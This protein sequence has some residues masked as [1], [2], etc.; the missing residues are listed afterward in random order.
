MFRISRH[1]R[2]ATVGLILA[3]S[4]LL[5][6]IVAVH[7]FSFQD[8]PSYLLLPPIPND[9]RMPL[10]ISS[11]LYA[12]KTSQHQTEIEPDTLS[13]G[14]TIVTAFQ[15]GRFGDGGSSNIGWATSTDGGNTWKSGFLP[16]TAICRR[17]L[18]ASQRSL[19]R[20]RRCSCHMDNLF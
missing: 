14:S 12:N 16:G 5:M 4:M 8:K 10:Q 20:L 7:A 11:D 6:L 9:E 15:V 19:R 1:P 13:Y 3:P 17:S 2:L 18:Y